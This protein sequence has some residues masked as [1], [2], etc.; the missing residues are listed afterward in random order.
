MD[1]F[2]GSQV[3]VI[4]LA[5][6]C[7][8]GV[9]PDAGGVHDGTGA[10]LE[11]IGG[12]GR[13]DLS[14]AE[15]AGGVLQQAGHRGVVGG[16]D[17]VLEGRRA[18]DRQRQAGIVGTGVVVEEAGH[19]TPRAQRR[20][21]CVDLLRRDLGV[22]VA[23]PPAAGEVVEPQCHGVALHDALVDDAALAEEGDDEREG[24]HEVRGVA[25]EALPLDEVLV[26]EK[27]LPLLQ[28]AKAPVYEL[29]GLRRGAGGE[30]PLLDEGRPQPAGGGVEGDTGPGDAT[31]DD[32]D[33]EGLRRQSLE[34]HLP[35]EAGERSAHDRP[36]ACHMPSRV[37]PGRS[38][39]LPAPRS[40]SWR[41]D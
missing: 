3:V 22:A 14:P 37:V 4:G 1:A 29:G 33:V 39:R 7:R 13:D 25:E 17:T 23:D 2:G 12:A 8:H 9:R 24:L 35:V 16:D 18:Q 38:Q 41:T 19:D 6:E 27:E 11:R 21:V 36:Q 40:R 32:Q 20:E 5:V 30:V 28:V 15:A 10:D 26:H 34:G 31:A